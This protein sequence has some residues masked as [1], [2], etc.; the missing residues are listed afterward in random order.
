MEKKK[1]AVSMRKKLFMIMLA[2]SIIPTV[3]ITV[4]ATVNT[5]HRLYQ[6][7]IT[8]NTEGMNQS[9]G[10][11]Q[12]YTEDM[13]KIFYA[14]EFDPDYK[15]AV[16]KWSL[17]EET[18]QDTSKISDMMVTSL[19]QNSMLQD[20]NLYIPKVRSSMQ[21]QRA[22]VRIDSTA[23]NQSIAFARDNQMQTNIFFKNQAEELYAIHNMHRFQD[24]EL[25]AQITAK[26][27]PA[28]LAGI[29]SSSRVYERE[30][31]LILNDEAQIVLVLQQDN[32]FAT[33]PPQITHIANQTGS[34]LVGRVWYAEVEG[35]LVFSTFAPEEKLSVIK[36]VP[37]QDIIRSVLPTVYTGILVGILSLF[38]AIVLSVILS[39][40]MSRPVE[41]LA[42]RVKNIKMQSL[43]LEE[44]DDTGDEVSVLE[45]HISLF[46]SRIRNLIREEYEAKLEAR[47][48][49]F[50]ALQA[51]INPHFLHN[52]LQLIGSIALAKEVPQV[53]RV[54]TSLSNLMRYSMEMD[55]MYVTLEEELINLENYFF[56]QKQRFSDRF[57]VKMDIQE[58]VRE[59]MVPKLLI[60][61]IVENAFSHGFT[62]SEIQWKLV[63]TAEKTAEGKVRISIW[64]NGS[65][66]DASTVSRLNATIQTS[67]VQEST[68][69]EVSMVFQEAQHIGILNVHDRIRLS[70]SPTDGLRITSEEGKW[71]NVE[72]I[73]DERRTMP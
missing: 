10:M 34:T 30:R 16:T 59:C 2:V 57:S 35:N 44:D 71:T 9:H 62:K 36:I 29:V 64:D 17:G 53:Y 13:K 70:F 1:K 23:G 26:L 12:R 19:N 69:N 18:Y 61:P 20:L 32:A 39:R 47:T 72:L 6:D 60:Q 7:T 68:E 58:D 15:Q 14:M 27:R 46:V 28:S 5:Y 42:Q 55:R 50:K 25:I 41:K 38:G 40:F 31:I 63:I 37:K 48:A 22:G 4:F 43:V 21:V 33:L 45:H 54:S 67:S 3:I 8:I 66:M 56:I 73:F 51:Q 24:R 52:T 11:L 49:Q 65:G